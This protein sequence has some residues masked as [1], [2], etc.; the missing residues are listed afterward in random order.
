MPLD[1]TDKILLRE[2]D[3]DVRVSITQLA[4]KARIS[5]EKAH[6]RL[7]RLEESVI[8]GYWALQRMGQRAGAY[9][10]FLKDKSLGKQKPELIAFIAKHKGAA[11]IAE[12]EGRWDV[13]ISI[14]AT[15][16]AEFIHFVN[17]LLRYYGTALREKAIIKMTKAISLN[18]K[19][20][21]KERY[22]RASEDDFTQQ[23]PSYDVIDLT[24]VNAIASNAR[25]SYVELS[26]LTGLTSE[27][28][29][30]RFRRLLKE[31]AF[32]DLKPRINHQALG[33][34]YYHILLSLEQYKQQETIIRYYKQHPQ[35]VYLMT[36]LG[37]YDIHLELVLNPSDL[38]LFL[39]DLSGRFGSALSAYEVLRIVT[40]HKIRMEQ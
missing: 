40:E 11:W 1:E 24:I 38:S 12:T 25:M 13:V 30:R 4:K 28:I 14:L 27:A 16:D 10:I 20:L 34:S 9:K 37:M 36:H 22:V 23:A 26:K 8:T 19:Y 31:R 29:S 18:E 35:C 33:L 17:Q 39:T 5:K 3:K 6:Y 32:V 15:T 7:R 21:H 2:L